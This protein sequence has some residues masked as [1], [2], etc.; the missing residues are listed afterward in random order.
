MISL[1][2]N[3]KASHNPKYLWADK[4]PVKYNPCHAKPMQTVH[5]PIRLLPQRSVISASK[6]I[7]S[8]YT[9]PR[10]KQN[11]PNTKTDVHLE[12]AAQTGL[13]PLPDET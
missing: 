7:I 6:V 13:Y 9:F 8:K 4:R 5:T 10:S 12:N 1:L 2:G 3:C 11:D